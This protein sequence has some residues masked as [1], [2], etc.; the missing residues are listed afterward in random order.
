MPDQPH[1]EQEISDRFTE[2][3]GGAGFVF[4]VSYVLTVLARVTWST[5]EAWIGEL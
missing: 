5:V 2:I 4:L 3:L 1:N